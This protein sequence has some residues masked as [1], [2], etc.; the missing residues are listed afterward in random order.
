VSD[1]PGYVAYR[2]ASAVAGALPLSV[3]SRIGEL[4]G[5]AVYPFSRGRR[6][7]GVRHMRRVLGAS[8]GAEAAA[9]RMF[10]AYGRYWAEVFWFRPRR[11]SHVAASTEVEGIEHAID[12]KAQGLGAVY[13]LPHLGN[14]ELAAV[15]ARRH[16]IEV[17][18][19]AEALP[20]RRIADWFIGL[21]TQ[22]GI[23]VLLTDDRG[24][25]TRD[26]LRALRRGAAVALVAD[27]DLSRKGVA[28]EFFGEET[29]LPAGP[30]TLAL[31]AKVPLLPVATYFTDGARHRIVVMDPIPVPQDRPEGERVVEMTQALAAAFEEL[32]RR[33]PYQWHLLQ[34]NWPSDWARS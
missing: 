14:W 18:A 16:G 24:R 15:E 12:I 32:I 33:A 4:A 19:V 8:T 3:V 17:V 10:A 13:A 31:R 1:W 6:A 21:R 34:P 27:R 26:L 20:N 9:R 29:T 25:L 23:D 5:R 7:M 30:A 11:E 22:L 28:V 2:L